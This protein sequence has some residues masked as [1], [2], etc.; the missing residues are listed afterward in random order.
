MTKES[1][2]KPD[3]P[4]KA[5]S[6]RASAKAAVEA[7]QVTRTLQ[8]KLDDT[9]VLNYGRQIAREQ[10]ELETAEQRKKE[11]MSQLKADIEKHTSAIRSL[12]SKIATGYEYRAV[13]CQ[14]VVDGTENRVSIVRD[15][16]GEVIEERPLNDDELQ[17]GLPI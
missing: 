17:R 12:S 14:K 4:K 5:T 6:K 10:T 2:I 9:E 11:V 8:C 3:T 7:V 16:T 13:K 1:P 15:D